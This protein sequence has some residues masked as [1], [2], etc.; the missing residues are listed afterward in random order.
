MIGV[1]VESSQVAEERIEHLK[2]I[3]MP[4]KHSDATCTIKYEPRHR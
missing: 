1:V 4:M 3:A 2:S